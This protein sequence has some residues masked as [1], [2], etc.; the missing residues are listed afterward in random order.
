[1]AIYLPSLYSVLWQRPLK[2][3]GTCML[4]YQVGTNGQDSIVRKIERFRFSLSKHSLSPLSLSLSSSATMSSLVGT[5]LYMAKTLRLR[6]SLSL[7]LSL[8]LSFFTVPFK[9]KNPHLG[10]NPKAIGHKRGPLLPYTLSLVCGSFV[11]IFWY[12]F[13]FVLFSF[14][15]GD[16]GERATLEAVV[17]FQ[18]GSTCGFWVCLMFSFSGFSYF[19]CFGGVLRFV[20][21]MW[22]FMDPFEGVLGWVWFLGSWVF[23]FVVCVCGHGV[24][25]QVGGVEH[26]G[27][28]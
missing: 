4:S 10:L 18:L 12:F 23:Y 3:G 17:L 27:M 16:L 13:F 26:G 24:H 14:L 28:Q 20:E 7:S 22:C 9:P 11:H 8:S 19:L 5:S 25:W 15:H 21:S 6:A 2:D 1:M